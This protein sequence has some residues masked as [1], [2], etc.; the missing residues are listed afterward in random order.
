MATTTLTLTAAVRSH[1]GALPLLSGAVAMD[2]L[3]LDHISVTANRRL[4]PHGARPGV[5]R[6]R[7]RPT[8]LPLCESASTSSSRRS[9]C[10]TRDFITARSCACGS[11][12]RSRRTCWKERWGAGLHGHDRRLDS[13]HPES[14]YDVDPA[15]VN[16]YTDDEEHVTEWVAP[17]NV[18]KLPPGE[19]LAAMMAAGRLDAALSGMAG[20]GRSGRRR[21][22]GRPPPHRQL[23]RPQRPQLVP[24]F[25]NARA[26]GSGTSG[27]RFSRSTASLSSRMRCWRSTSGSRRSCCALSRRR[28]GA[29]PAAPRRRRAVNG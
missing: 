15:Q 16:W 21:P 9:R 17:P 27:R 6:V 18:V 19:S 13:R 2:G 12:I 24:L 3:R 22:T 5:R 20:I 8:T 28:R 14:E 26:W 7:A 10:L 25:P 11:G 23:L 1:G 29:P 4:P